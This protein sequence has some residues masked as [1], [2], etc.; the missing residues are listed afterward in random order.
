VWTYNQP[1]APE[2]YADIAEAMGVDTKGMNVPQAA[3]A[4]IEAVIRLVK[5][6]GCP[7]NWGQVGE[8]PKTRMGKGYYE[9]KTTA[10]I[11]SDDDELQKMAEHMMGDLCTPGNPRDLTVDGAK[12]VLRDCMYD[13][14]DVKTGNGY[15]QNIW[16]VAP[17]MGRRTQQT[18]TERPG[19]Q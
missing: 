18:A 16:G 14:M 5:D 13:G 10:A 12:E 11:Q 2:K 3:D 9:G 1:A 6:C 7:E 8:Y 4:A 17:E 15:R 19:P